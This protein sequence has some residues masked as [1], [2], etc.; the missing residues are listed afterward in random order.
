MQPAIYIYIIWGILATRLKL[1][2]NPLLNSRPYKPLYL[3]PICSSLLLEDIGINSIT[4]ITI[5]PT[6]IVVATLIVIQDQLQVLV[7][8][9]TCVHTHHVRSGYMHSKH[10]SRTLAICEME[11][12]HVRLGCC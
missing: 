6:S 12:Q 9:H 1:Y 3:Y 8:M 2:E 7:P 10:K 11:G 5:S 4:G